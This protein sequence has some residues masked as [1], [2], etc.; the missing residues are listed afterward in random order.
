MTFCPWSLK[1]DQLQ[2][3]EEEVRYRTKHAERSPSLRQGKVP[4]G[5]KGLTRI[6]EQAPEVLPLTPKGGQL[7]KDEEKLDIITKIKDLSFSSKLAS[8]TDRD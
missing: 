2:I 1:G 6:E 5:R 8:A 3:D 4:V 7:Q